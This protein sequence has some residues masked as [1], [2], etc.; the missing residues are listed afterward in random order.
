MKKVLFVATVVK[1][2]IMEFHIP[3]LKLFKEMGWETSV[4]AHNDYKDPNQCV[5]PYCDHYYDIPFVR[6]PLKIE[7]LKAYKD[8]KSVIDAGKYDIIHCHTPVGAMI[9]RLASR[10]ARSEKGSKVIYTAHGFHF[11]SGAP[12]INWALYYPVERW[13]SKYTD[14]LITINTEDYER[15]KRLHAKKVCYIPGVGIDS[16]KFSTTNAVRGV[17]REKICH[18][19]GI[20]DNALILLSVGEVNKNKNHAIVI[21]ALHRL[22]ETNIYYIVCGSGPLINEHKEKAKRLRLDTRVIFAGYR[23]DVVSFYKAADIFVFPSHREGLPVAVMEAMASG[24]PVIATNIRGNKDLISSDSCGL[25]LSPNDVDGFAEAIEYYIDSTKRERARKVNSEKA[26]AFDLK[27]IVKKYY[28]VYCD[29]V[30]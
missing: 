15:A 30:K 17:E 3:Y 14:V 12:L 11:Y 9:T 27:E 20:P 24:L 28:N 18:E 7:N 23:T 10:Q 16:C 13:L 4:A 8:L 26:K 6:N 1:M 5:I 19:F 21:E 22:A 2:H 29:E 25:L